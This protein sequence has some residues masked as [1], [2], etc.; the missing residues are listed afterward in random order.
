MTLKLPPV[1][2]RNRHALEMAEF[3]SERARFEQVLRAFF[4]ACREDGHDLASIDVL[5]A[6]GATPGHKGAQ[7]P[8]AALVQR[9]SDFV[10]HKK[11]SVRPV[12]PV[13]RLSFRPSFCNHDVYA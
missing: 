8:E 13:T 3:A 2:P 5:V 6:I 10:V 7:L 9:E 1:Q 11:L 12:N 4:A